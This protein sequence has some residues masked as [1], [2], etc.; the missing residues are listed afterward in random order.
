MDKT[1][2]CNATLRRR[3]VLSFPA[4][5]FVGVLMAALCGSV[6]ARAADTE[7]AAPPVADSTLEAPV[8]VDGVELF[9]VRG[10]KSVV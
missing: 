3:D 5:I 4:W 8:V 6:T 2:S 10:G 9:K 7:T 1:M